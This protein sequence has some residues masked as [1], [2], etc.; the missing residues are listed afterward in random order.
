VAEWLVRQGVPFRV[1]HE[2]AGGCVQA[3]EARGVGLAELTDAELAGVDPHLTPAVREV[4]TVDGSI[5]SRDAHGGTAG[6][7]VTE[8]LA[9]VR[10]TAA[11]HRA[12]ASAG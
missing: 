11:E 12:W 3:A 8:Q 7:R 2:A 5:A 4:L 1:A 10:S 9:G 6:V